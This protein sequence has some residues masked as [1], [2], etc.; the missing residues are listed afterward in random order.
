MPAKDLR[1]KG[2]G[3]PGLE[4]NKKEEQFIT[5]TIISLHICIFVAGKFLLNNVFIWDTSI[6]ALIFIH[7]SLGQLR[8][9]TFRDM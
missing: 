9:S 6:I 8:V 4:V 2:E 1:G 7:L 3:F 5:L